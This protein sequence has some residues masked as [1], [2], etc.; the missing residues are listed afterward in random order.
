MILEILQNDMKQAMKDKDVTARDV[1]R[2]VIGAVK[3]TAIDECCD[4][5]EELID[6]VLLKEKKIL[7]EQID[8]CP[9][10][11]PVYLQEYKNKMT[12][13]DK[14]CPKLLDNPEE[15]KDIIVKEL[16]AA[17]L[18]PVKANKGAVMKLLMPQFKGKADM[19]IVNQVIGE[20]L[21]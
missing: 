16:A 8:T 17:G 20:L 21:K 12:V 1:L 15:I 9:A 7:Q 4:T 3:K 11:R 10:D 19:K 2:S 5:T 6:R 13:L 14:Y 18:E